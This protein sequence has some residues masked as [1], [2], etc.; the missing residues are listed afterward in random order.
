MSTD[1]GAGT[2]SGA[3]RGSSSDDEE[4]VSNGRGGGSTALE[5]EW[6]ES[7]GDKVARMPPPPTR[8]RRGHVQGMVY[9]ALRCCIYFRCWSA[10]HPPEGD[11]L[12][13]MTEY[14]DTL[15]VDGVINCCALNYITTKQF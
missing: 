15:L 8:R 4:S 13:R 14:G 12:S 2:S 5:I 1:G 9:P 7:G 3:I 6:D 11:R 10:V